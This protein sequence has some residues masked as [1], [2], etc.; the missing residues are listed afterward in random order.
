MSQ[1]KAELLYR[2]FIMSPF[3]YCPIIWMFSGKKANKIIDNTH[4]RGLRAVLNN[5]TLS[6][7]EMLDLNKDTVIHKK[8]LVILLSEVYKS[9]N[10]LNPE[11]MKDLFTSK[12]N[13][14]NLRVGETLKIPAAKSSRGINSIR[15]RG[16]MAWNYLP[17]EIK[18]SPTL[19][20]FKERIKLIEI[21][22][23]CKVCS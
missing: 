18:M 19:N 12:L 1:P 21:H 23:C 6:F 13:S 20:S 3:T 8:N 7:E 5:F 9:I 16:A 2:S 22:C 17:K 14:H 11:F 10:S 15:F 4:R